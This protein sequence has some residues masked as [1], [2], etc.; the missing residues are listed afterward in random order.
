MFGP[1]TGLYRRK[2]LSAQ[3]CDSF[4]A[5]LRRSLRV[6]AV[7]SSEACLENFPTAIAEC[8]A[9][10]AVA[11]AVAWLQFKFCPDKPARRGG[12]GHPH[13]HIF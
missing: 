7:L 1:L 12:F 4:K 10:L 13:D 8:F 3:D 11:G 9:D 2:L 5:G 6:S